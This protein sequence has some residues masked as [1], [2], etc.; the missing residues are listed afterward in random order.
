MVRINKIAVAMRSSS[1]TVHGPQYVLGLN[2]A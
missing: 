2:P 1:N